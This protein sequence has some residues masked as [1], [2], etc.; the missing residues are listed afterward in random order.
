MSTL[1]WVHTA[2]SLVALATGAAVLLMRKGTR[3]HRTVG[4]LY[5]TSMLSLNITALLIYRLFDGFGPFH[6]MAVASLATLAAGMAP[7]LT[8]RPQQRWLAVHAGCM[9]GS[10]VGLVAAAASEVTSRMGG[11]FSRAVAIT[12]VLVIGVGLAI[13]RRTLPRAIARVSRP[14]RP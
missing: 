14:P 1:G 7:A 12:T 3:W 2:F 13:I 9:S 4:H 10:Y 8:R 6:W 11:D 5:L